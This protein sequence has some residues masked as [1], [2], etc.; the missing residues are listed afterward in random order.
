MLLLALLIAPLLVAIPCRLLYRRQPLIERLNVAGAL[1]TAL[2]AG[3][4]VVDVASN[5]PQ[6]DPIGLFYVDALSAVLIGTV[7]TVGLAAALVSVGYLRR[8]LRAGHLLDGRKDLGWYYFGFHIFI[9]TMLATVSVANLGLL[10]VGI[11]ATTLASALLVGFYRTKAALEAAWKYIILCT[12]GITFALFG[13]LLTYYAAVQASGDGASLEWTALSANA[14]LL[15]PALMKLAFVF[16]LI[17]FGTK[18]GF[19]PL[20]TWLADAHSQAPSPI[21]GVLSGV[22]LA[23]ALYAI[24]R[25]QALTAAATGTDFASNLLLAF[26][27][28]SVA[29]ALPFIVIQRD[30]KRLLAYSS[31]EHIGLMAV[32]FGIG[33]PLGMAAGLLHLVNHALTKALLFFVAGDIAQRFGTRRISALR[34]VVRIAPLAGWLLL[35]GILAIAGMPPFSIFV[36]EIA[37][38]SAGF[39]GSREALIASALVVV[40]LGL[41]FAGL[42]AQ[43]LRVVY[44]APPAEDVAA[45]HGGSPRRVW[46]EDLLWIAAVAPLALAVLLLGLHVPGP[47]TDLFD[48]VSATLQPLATTASR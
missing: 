30:L 4:V 20:H 46:R 7:A 40:L 45:S 17:G 42:L 43:G 16:I 41:I 28:F 21:S 15:D 32:A 29:V 31:V 5:G 18:A 39:A 35:A 14:A 48:D 6:D 13:V 37:I 2:L 10:W 34:G 22:L 1:L 38:A 23:C 12:V 19:A 8:D 3:A 33:G 36:S 26:G 47:V 24:L 27:V 9:W 25:F 44:G 11:E